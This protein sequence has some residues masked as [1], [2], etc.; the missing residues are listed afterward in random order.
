MGD[1][2]QAPAGGDAGAPMGDMGAAGA[3]APGPAAGG[4]P[5]A[6]GL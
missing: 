1:G 3:P 5:P 2:T 6:G 4:A